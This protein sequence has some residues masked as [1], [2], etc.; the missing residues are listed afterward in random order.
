MLARAFTSST[1]RLVIPEGSL[2]RIAKSCLFV[3]V[4]L[5]ASAAL[6]A[7]E[8]KTEDQ[9]TLYAI[10]LAISKSIAVFN[11][12]AAD[13]EMVKAGMTDGVLNKES[14]VDLEANRP[15]IAH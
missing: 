7:P 14:K 13:L 12:S 9:K 8:P 15:K 11:L 1:N 5:V 3:L 4:S 10:G 6:A 2:M